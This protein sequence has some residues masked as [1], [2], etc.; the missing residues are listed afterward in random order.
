MSK[1]VNGIQGNPMK[2]LVLVLLSITLFQ[3]LGAMSNSDERKHELQKQILEVNNELAL[4]IK[5]TTD[6]LNTKKSSTKNDDLKQINKKRSA[7]KRKL[8]PLKIK[9]EA[10]VFGFEQ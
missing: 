9:Y 7:L 10:L 3:M 2:K 4:L 6:L 8:G 5:Q 1:N